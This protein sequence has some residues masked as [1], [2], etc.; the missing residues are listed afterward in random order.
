MLR[1][2]L[3]PLNRRQ[4]LGATAGLLA[5]G[6][7]S[8]SAAESKSYQLK[9]ALASCMYGKLP[10]AEILP[11]VK[12]TGSEVLDIWPLPHG[13]QREQIEKM[14]HDAFAELLDKHAVKLGILTHY[15]LGPFRLSED[16]AFA[17]RFGVKLMITGGSGP[18]NLKGDELKSAVK[19][20]VK[21]LEPQLKIAEEHGYSI[22]IENH[23][24]NLIESPDSLRWL[25]E[26]SPSP[27]L[28]IALAPYHLPQNPE[29]LGKLI[30]DLGDRLLHF[31]AWEHGH[32]CMTKLPKEEELLQLPAR[33]ELNF[34]PVVS[35]LETINFQ[36]W[37]EIFMHPVPRG[38]PILPTASAVTAEI[39]RN[40]R[41]LAE[42]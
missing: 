40:R 9:W 38:I 28:G 5:A 31:Y 42:L 2:A 25:A 1:S 34:G 19:T 23:G 10:L 39:N 33:G 7:V 36:G 16:A 21:K 35:A 27:R 30:E 15:R 14:G 26:F 41:F 8:G 24:N 17:K 37:T 11:E 18:K 20:F 4:F 12:K 3:S 22:G 29:Q 13:D 6:A 32:G